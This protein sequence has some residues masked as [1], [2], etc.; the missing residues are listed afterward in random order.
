MPAPCLDT[1][2]AAIASS[3]FLSD[4]DLSVISDLQL[5]RSRAAARDRLPHGDVFSSSGDAGQMILPPHVES[6]IPVLSYALPPVYNSR[7]DPPRRE[8]TSA[9]YFDDGRCDP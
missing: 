5:S 3:L 4:L 2:L 8:R 9:S 6:D 1:R 7:F